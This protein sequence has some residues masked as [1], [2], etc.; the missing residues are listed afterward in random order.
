MAAKR[1]LS[2]KVLE[3]IWDEETALCLPLQV[4]KLPVYT[5]CMLRAFV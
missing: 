4:C 5:P 2:M 3:V 1:Q